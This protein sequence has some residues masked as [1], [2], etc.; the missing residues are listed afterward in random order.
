MRGAPQGADWAE[1]ELANLTLSIWRP[2]AY[3]QPFQPVQGG[4]IA[5]SVPDVKVAREALEAKGVVFHEDTMDTSVCHMAFFNDTE[6][7]A[8][9]L[10]RRYAPT[11]ATADG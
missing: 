10:H 5:L 3:G 7:N 1:F 8:L 2:E 11:E 9:M 6:G 4:Q